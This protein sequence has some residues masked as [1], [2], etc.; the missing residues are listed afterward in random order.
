MPDQGSHVAVC[1]RASSFVLLE[2]AEK[3]RMSIREDYLIMSFCLSSH[4][5]RIA[6]AMLN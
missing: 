5:A 6:M 3:A 4:Q 2:F 1:P